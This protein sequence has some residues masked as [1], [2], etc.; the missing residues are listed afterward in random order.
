MNSKK[1]ILIVEDSM[2]QAL[3]LESILKRHDYQVAVARNGIEGLSYLKD[4]LPD[5]VISDIIMPGM[6]GYE[7]CK[8]I[9]SS[10]RLKGIPVILLTALSDTEDV[11]KA[12]E[13]KANNFL[14]K[15]YD[16]NLLV[17]RINNTLLNHGL[18]KSE[19]TDTAGEAGCAEFF[20]AGK[21]HCITSDRAQIA[22]LLFSTYEN[23]IQKN[24]ELEE[25]N[26]KLV[27][28]QRKL[29]KDIVDLE[30]A[31]D[32]LQ[33][34]KE[35]L[36]NILFHIPH[37][38]FWKN[39]QSI[40]LG[41]N[42]SFAKVVKLSSPKNIIGKTD[43]D[44][45]WKRKESD[46]YLQFDKKVMDGDKPIL[47][48][49]KS[50]VK[51]DGTV[52]NFLT[53]NVPLRDVNGNVF[54]ILGIYTDITEQVRAKE[55]LVRAKEDAES[56]NIAKSEFLANMSHEIR[57][58]MNGIIG[59]TGLLLDSRLTPEQLDYAETIRNS[60]DALLAIINDI[61]DFSK[62]ETG[63]FELE[64]ID[65]NIRTVIEE[66]TDLLAT[67]AYDKGLKFTS[68]VDHKVP[69]LLVGDPGRL[70]QILMNLVG[71][72]IKFTEKGEVVVHAKIKEE[73]DTSVTIYFSV[74]DTGIGI[75][76]E[77]KYNLFQSFTQID[78]STT[79]RYGGTGLGLA[80]SKRIADMMGGQ[81]GVES[82]KGKGSTFWFTAVFRKQSAALDIPHTPVKK[83]VKPVVPP[84]NLA[85]DKKQ[86]IRILL[87]EDNF[88]NQ[89][90]ALKIIE[91]DGHH[92]DV[93]NNGREAIKALEA[94]HYDLVLMDILMP[95]M[96]GFEATAEIRNPMSA[97]RNHDIPI[98]AMTAYAMKGDRKKCL[99]AGMNDYISKP[100]RPQELLSK[101]D[102]WTGKGKEDYSPTSD[103]AQDQEQ[104]PAQK[105]SSCKT[106]KRSPVDIE[107]AIEQV[108]GDKD[109]LK[110][111][112]QLFVKNLPEQIEALKTALA[113]GDAQELSRIA[114][115]LKGSSAN[116]RVNG[117]NDVA[118]RLE[119]IGKKGNLEE[120]RPA[121]AELVDEFIRLKE[122]IDKIDD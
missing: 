38:V 6:D 15:P 21:K 62:L 70:R 42:N 2:T 8:H 93:A 109:F 32:K 60:S 36:D 29:E 48:I 96:D 52:T 71:N 90:V 122:Y 57:T 53:S 85:E 83:P 11:I 44:L 80:I 94:D 88:V 73:T 19:T 10:D 20:F 43:Y 89:K 31:E 67:E 3:K 14:T 56:A 76:Q 50:K 54:G 51:T 102:I 66:V 27:V 64:N 4:R 77:K 59:M 110:E 111:L 72:G 58:P 7:L 18:R 119:Q 26:Q 116:L 23:A 16:E 63:K 92:V 87:T 91:K 95:E 100:V 81:I 97:V 49:E 61:L 46:F 28:M 114:H 39:R 35:L 33:N 5:L 98:I 78:A 121:L 40:Y 17:S 75:S 84:R 69:S 34:Q 65:L 106:D 1:E 25:A 105:N 86:K 118:L 74:T 104:P 41:C 107:K 55:E 120:A 9:K 79:R 24:R 101:I 13:C 108:M 68:L 82:R 117:I 103:Q 30:R 112:L 47:N 22:D 99:E 45:G 37:L 12:L 113:G 115:T